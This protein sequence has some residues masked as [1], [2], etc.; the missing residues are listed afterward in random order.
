MN[1]AYL[2]ECRF[3][4]EE[5]EKRGMFWA[6]LTSHFLSRFIKPRDVVMDIGAGSLEFLLSCRAKEKIAVDPIFGKAQKKHNIRCY[7]ML[8]DVPKTYRQAVDV[9][10]LSNVLEHLR[11]RDEIMQMLTEIRRLLTPTGSL[12]IIQP[13]I[14]LVGNR[15]WNFFDHI[16]PI[17]RTSLKEALKV[18]GYTVDVFIPRFLPYTTKLPFPVPSFL[19]IL[20]LSLPWYLRPFA[21]QCFVRAKPE[22]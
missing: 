2:Y 19:L 22:K 6:T 17:T 15:Y 5:Q 4:Q 10:M 7:H 13:T 18:A 14:D 12:L 3:S 9:V 8:S 16:T 21:G 1:H 11:D 20:Y